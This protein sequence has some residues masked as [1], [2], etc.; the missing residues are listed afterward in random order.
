MSFNKTNQPTNQPTKKYAFNSYFCKY[1]CE[2]YQCKV[3]IKLTKI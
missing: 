3:Y 2:L 1:E